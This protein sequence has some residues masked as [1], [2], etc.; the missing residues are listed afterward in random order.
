M[1]SLFNLEIFSLKHVD[2]T[3]EIG[4]KNQ[5]KKSLKI[6]Y[7]TA[8]G[9]P[10]LQASKNQ[11]LGSKSAVDA[12]V[13]RLPGRLP[14]VGFPTV[15]KV[16]QP[17]SRPPSRQWP[18]GRLPDRPSHFQ[19]ADT[20]WRSTLRSIGPTCAR[21]CI[22]VDQSSRPTSYP[23]DRPVDRQEVSPGNYGD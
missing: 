22:S 11:P 20:L 17:A 8:Q 6:L 7:K 13:G 1:N 18:N 12:A 15:G 14:T 3:T 2:E 9:N 5:P 23:I 4:W 19:R 10:N 21:L 16:G